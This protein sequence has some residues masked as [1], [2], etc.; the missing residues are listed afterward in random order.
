MNKICSEKDFK[1]LNEKYEKVDILLTLLKCSVIYNADKSILK[2]FKKCEQNEIVDEFDKKGES[3]LSTNNEVIKDFN[4]LKEISDKLNSLK[5]SK[6]S[7]G[8][9]SKKI[10]ALTNRWIELNKSIMDKNTL[11]EIID[12]GLFT[13]TQLDLIIKNF[14]NVTKSKTKIDSAYRALFG[15]KSLSVKC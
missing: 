2:E 11:F 4:K 6:S 3:I 10:I 1:E 9:D 5:T 15:T 14:S 12:T 7:F 13:P 8:N